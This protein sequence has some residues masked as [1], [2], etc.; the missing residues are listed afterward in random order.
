MPYQQDLTTHPYL[1]AMSRV[2]GWPPP[3]TPALTVGW[4]APE[5]DFP[6]ALPDDAFL[7][8][9]FYLC[10]HRSIIRTR[11]FHNCLLP[12]ATRPAAICVVRRGD[13]EVRLGSAEIGVVAAGGELLLAPNLVFHYIEEHHYQPP[14]I[15]TE[16]VLARRTI[17]PP[18]GVPF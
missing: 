13:E 14:A 5:H 2:K 18:A 7:D 1:E 17:T 8:A 9:L 3:G 11:G 10:A 16:A 12:H 15:F 4:L 6:T